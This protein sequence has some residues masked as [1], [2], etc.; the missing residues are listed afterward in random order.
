MLG[1]RK[2]FSLAEIVVACAIIIGLTSCAV[3]TADHMM[4]MGR[5]NAA[6]ASVAA[7]SVAVARYRHDIGS[8]PPNLLTLTAANETKGPWL[9]ADSLRDPWNQDYMFYVTDNRRQFAVWSSGPDKINNSTTTPTVNGF[10]SDDIGIIS[11]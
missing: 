8:F 6:K 3:T 4:K 1:N 9:S 2:G 11:Q 7:I 5:Y 10:Q